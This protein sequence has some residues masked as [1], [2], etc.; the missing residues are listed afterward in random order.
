MNKRNSSN[1]NSIFINIDVFKVD[2]NAAYGENRFYLDAD[3]QCIKYNTSININ[4]IVEITSPNYE[5]YTS[6]S[7][8]GTA[9]YKNI[10]LFKIKLTN[11]TTLYIPESEYK[12]FKNIINNG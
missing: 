9:L 11:N 1:K 8:S 10:N 3:R 5:K 7:T 12:K 6:I 2:F 4:Y